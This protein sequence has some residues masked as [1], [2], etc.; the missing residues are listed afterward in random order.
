MPPYQTIFFFIRSDGSGFP[1]PHLLGLRLVR[2]VPAERSITG[3]QI[4]DALYFFFSSKAMKVTG[5][6][7]ENLLAYIV[8]WQSSPDTCC[9]LEKGKCKDETRSMNFEIDNIIDDVSA[10]EA[11]GHP[12]QDD[13]TANRSNP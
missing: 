12:S 4:P 11:F 3:Y 2:G 5:L 10:A 7:L 6:N 1:L 13:I 9:V 8:E